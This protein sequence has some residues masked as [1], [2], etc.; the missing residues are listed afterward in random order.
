HP[1]G[2]VEHGD[3]AAAEAELRVRRD[4]SRAAQLEVGWVD[5]AHGLTAEV[6]REHAVTLLQHVEACRAER[7]RAVDHCGGHVEPTNEVVL[8]AR[9][10]DARVVELDVRRG[11]AVVRQRDRDEGGGEQRDRRNGGRRLATPAQSRQ[12]SHPLAPTVVTRAPPARAGPVERTSGYATSGM[13]QFLAPTLTGRAC[14]HDGDNS[15]FVAAATR[16]CSRAS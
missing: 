12:R 10:P 16:G 14:P 6:A 15:P 3:D 9:D 11:D 5:G 8:L 13:T 1:Q 7:D 2:R 4:A